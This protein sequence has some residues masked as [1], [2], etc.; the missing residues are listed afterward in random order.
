MLKYPRSSDIPK[1]QELLLLLR[2]KPGKSYKSTPKIAQALHSAIDRDDNNAVS[3]VL[4]EKGNPNILLGSSNLTPLQ[5]AFDNKCN[6]L[7]VLNLVI[8]GANLE[9]RDITFRQTA[10]TRAIRRCFEPGYISLICELGADVNAVDIDGSSALHIAAQL[11]DPEHVLDTIKVLTIHGADLDLKDNNGRTA[12]VRATVKRHT[13]VVERLLQYDADPDAAT[14][15]GRTA[16]FIATTNGCIP[17]AQLLCKHKADL[18]FVGEE[19]TPLS[20]AIRSKQD[21]IT[22]LLINSGADVNQKCPR[23]YPL[24]V[25]AISCTRDLPKSTILQDLLDRKADP[26]QVGNSGLTPIQIATHH[27]RIDYVK[28][29][30]NAGARLETSH[31]SAGTPLYIAAGKGNLEIVRLLIDRGADLNATDHTGCTVLHV[32]IDSGHT[33]VA[34]YLIEA[35]AGIHMASGKHG[36][37]PIH[38][39]AYKAD[40]E[41]VDLLIGYGSSIEATIRPGHTPFMCAVESG[42]IAIVQHLL[43]LGS[44][45]HA[46]SVDGGSALFWAG[47][48][49]AMIEFVID[50]GVDVNLRDKY[51]VSALHYTAAEGYIAGVRTLLRRGAEIYHASCIFDTLDDW[52]ERRN[53]M[54]GTPIDLARKKGHMEVVRLLEVM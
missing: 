43:S 14:P 30:L 42:D 26:N 40:I 8:A 12:L 9:A 44:D 11:D 7:L 51:G 45:P 6:S 36:F 28:A 47:K 33:A 2:P 10:L 21:S 24:V 54:A 15:V 17:I 32:A 3:K 50:L 27:D 38:W 1:I 37:L 23:G 29:L 5:R 53:P 49:P 20:S 34:K 39:A 22:R 48:F 31:P 13:D 35:G 4:F 41:I 25:I 18:N 52:L 16:L 46:R 19:D